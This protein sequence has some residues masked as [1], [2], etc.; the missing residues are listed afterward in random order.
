MNLFHT[1]TPATGTPALRRKNLT[2]D[3][4]TFVAFVPNG[5][6]VRVIPRTAEEVNFLANLSKNINVFVPE[7]GDG[8][9]VLGAVLP[10]LR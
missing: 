5:V 2:G 3:D 10:A 8:L 1:R 4:F 6:T 7:S 9:L